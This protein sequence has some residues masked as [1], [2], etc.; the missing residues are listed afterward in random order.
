MF[1]VQPLLHHVQV[2]ESQESAA[3]PESEGRGGLALVRQGRIVER[4]LP[5]GVFE[6]AV[7][8]G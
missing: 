3:E 6:F 8:V 4:Q 7:V 5:E 2:Q 1:P